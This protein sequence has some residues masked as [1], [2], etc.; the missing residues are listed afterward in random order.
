[1]SD[2]YTWLELNLPSFFKSVGLNP[3]YASGSIGSSGDKCYGAIHKFEEAGLHFYHGVAIYIILGFSPFS[4]KVR[5][6]ENGWVDPF[7]W[8]VEN[9]DQFTPYLPEVIEH[10]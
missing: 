6:T 10:N 5:N 2:H 1:M 3:E 9:K 4:E 8:I 7:Q